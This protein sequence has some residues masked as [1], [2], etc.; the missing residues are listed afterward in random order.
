MHSRTFRVALEAVRALRPAALPKAADR[1]ARTWAIV[2][3]QGL[4]AEQ[5]MGSG[6]VLVPAPANV[7]Q[8]WTVALSVWMLLDLQGCQRGVHAKI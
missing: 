6:A 3:D 1:E 8:A 4:C 7:Q 5:G 2:T